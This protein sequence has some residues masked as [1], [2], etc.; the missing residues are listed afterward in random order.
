M[1][2]GETVRERVEAGVEAWLNWLPQWEP[3]SHRGRARICRRCMGSPILVAAGITAD[4]PHQVSHALV[5]RMQRII[6]RQVELLT[7]R[8]LPTLHAELASDA[9]WS[10]GKY[11]PTAGLD[12]EYDGLDPDPELDSQDQPYLFTLAGLAEETDAEP[13]LPRPPLS[14]DEKARLRLEIA[15]ADRCA[16][17]AGRSVCFALMGHREKIKAALKR[18]VEPKIE[19]LLEELSR[20][21]EPPR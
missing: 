10:E 8:E 11:D 1:S 6:D 2:A 15:E 19:E 17:E 7:E 4:T 20:H 9:L 5:S 14:A 21:L 12:P 13:R 3:P 16:E 18:F